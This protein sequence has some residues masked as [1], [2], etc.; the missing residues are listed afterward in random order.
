[1][2]QEK[3]R[4][5]TICFIEEA[6]EHL[7]TIEHGLLNLESMLTDPEAVNEVF[8]AAHSIKGGAA[9]LGY[10]GIQT[11]AHNFED[12]FKIFRDHQNLKVDQQLQTYFLECFDKLRDLI[13]QL[14]SPE[15]LSL[16]KADAIVRDSAPIFEQIKR[17]LNSLAGIKPEPV[18]APSPPTPPVT[19]VV[20]ASDRSLVAAFKVEVPAKLR[21]MLQCFKQPDT[22]KNRENLQ[23]ICDQLKTI[24]DRFN[25]PQ[26]SDLLQAMRAVLGNPSL[27]FRLLAPLAIREIKQAQELVLAG[28]ASAIQ[29]SA[30]VR[31]VMP[32]GVLVG[33]ELRRQQWQNFL[34]QVG[35]LQT[36]ALQYDLN[37]PEGHLPAPIW[38][39]PWQDN[40]FINGR[41]LYEAFLQKLSDCEIG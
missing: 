30:Q 16:D 10:T 13:E 28:R 26:W 4:Q 5:I 20:P 35:W 1:M 8:R 36:T 12:N 17:H 19:P 33:E 11:L 14:E 40:N 15:G 37:A 6:K 21:E 38:L 32:A 22:P 18:T 25:L 34:A 41:S 9:M 29:I 27:Q 39:E 7:D 31:E 3:Q 24:G 23:A 2:D